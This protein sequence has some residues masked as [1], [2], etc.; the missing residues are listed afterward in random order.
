MAA[1]ATALLL[2]LPAT[3]FG[4][5]FDDRALIAADGHPLAVGPTLAYRPLRYASYLVDSLFGGSA[6]VY[7]LHNALLHAAV[8]AWTAT[9]ARRVGC[10]R[11]AA[12]VAG[13]LVAVHPLAVEAAAYVSGRR[14]LLGVA[15]GLGALLALRA[16]RLTGASL[17][18]VLAAAAK[19]SALVFTA[20]M[21]AMVVT[22]LDRGAAPPVPAARSV[23][24][25]AVA[26]LAAFVMTIAYGAIGP[27]SPPW[28]A[29]GAAFPGHVALHYA[30]GL[31]GLRPLSVDYPVLLE[32]ADRLRGGEGTAIAAGIAVTLLLAAALSVSVVACTR[33][34]RGLVSAPLALAAAWSSAVAVA[35]AAVGGLHEPGVDRHAYLLL[36]ALGLVLAVAIERAPLRR[37]RAMLV[38]VAPLLLWGATSSRAQMKV[39]SNE[40]ALW[41]HAA[42]HAPVSTR[43]QANLARVLA[44]EGRYA[45]ARRRL[46]AALA[47]D[48]RDFTLHLGRAAVRCAMGRRAAARLDLEAARRL[49]APDATV[50]DLAGECPLP[51]LAEA[52]RGAPLRAAREN[53]T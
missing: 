52:L 27:W 13:L 18:L 1:A 33:A 36:P 24:T 47:A 3:G 30:T 45:E 28:T 40:N 53:A 5:V 41:T 50:A 38:A 7:H 23:A 20:P 4:F 11:A 22:G 31:I 15:L 37:R 21:L 9:L 26:A 14:D 29:A 17:L 6:A 35:M 32:T 34:R 8:A 19:E 2:Y 49:G 39:W 12:L 48:P 51:R 44:G 16:G 42:A 46:G 43:T 10:G 25:I